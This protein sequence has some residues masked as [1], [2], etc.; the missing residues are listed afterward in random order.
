MM[1]NVLVLQ[2]HLSAWRAQSERALLEVMTF[3]EDGKR[4]F[5]QQEVWAVGRR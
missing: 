2:L 4:Q 5:N 1:G 3:L